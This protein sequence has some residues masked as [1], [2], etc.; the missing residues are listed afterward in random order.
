MWSEPTRNWDYDP[1]GGPNSGK[2]H[3]DHGEI[4]RAECIRK[5]LPIP[6]PNQLLHGIC[7]MRKGAGLMLA[8][9]PTNG[10]GLQPRAMNWPI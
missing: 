4:S 3:A 5:G 6:L 10:D 2:L 8:G 1:D 7:N 9:A